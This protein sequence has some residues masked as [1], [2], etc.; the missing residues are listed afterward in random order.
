[1]PLDRD[2]SSMG[3]LMVIFDRLGGKQNQQRGCRKTDEHHVM[4][5]T[6]GAGLAAFELVCLCACQG[7]SD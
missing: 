1:M 2:Q 5:S 3:A 4:R 7:M 6:F